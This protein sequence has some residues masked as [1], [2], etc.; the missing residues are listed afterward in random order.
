VFLKIYFDA[1][2]IV[3]VVFLVLF[4]VMA[5]TFPFIKQN[6]LY[7]I[8]TRNTFESKEVWR[9][10]HNTIAILII[11]FA[12][13]LFAILFIKD[14]I[15]ETI[16]LFIIVFF[17]FVM[18]GIVDHIFGRQYFREKEKKEKRELEMRKKIES[19]WR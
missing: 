8:R 2:T 3:T 1:T 12:I 10:V 19:G 4:I 18:F 7:G 6:P 11:P 17:S 13:A 9:K 16:L 15:V 5:I 14:A